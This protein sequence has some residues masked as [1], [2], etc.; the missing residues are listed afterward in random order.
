MFEPSHDEEDARAVCRMYFAH[1]ALG[2]QITPGPG[3]IAVRQD[4]GSLVYDVNHVQIAGEA[5]PE[6][7]LEFAEETFS[8]RPYRQVFV[9]P[10]TSPAL[11]AR[12]AHEGFEPDPHLIGLLKGELRGPA[13]ADIEIRLVESAMDWAHLA[14]LVRADHVEES[15]KPGG[16]QLSEEFTRQI[17]AVRRLDEHE[18]QFF[19]AWD[20]GEPVGFFS[21]WP[22]VG[23]VGIVED[24]FTLPS[25][26]NRGIARALIHHCVSDARKRGAGPILIGSEPND[27][28][29]EIYRAMGF[30]PACLAHGWLKLIPS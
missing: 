27:T 28:P 17:Q 6:A 8:D 22:G 21:S 25:H 13:P 20:F 7:V 16:P 9:T 23:G 24:L 30:E 14:R 12:L 1:R 29:K 3:C 18:V 5:D 26:R 10:F 11:V 2:C 4:V 15:A 19:T